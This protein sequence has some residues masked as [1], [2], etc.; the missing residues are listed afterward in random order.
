MYDTPRREDTLSAVQGARPS[1]TRA[2]VAMGEVLQIDVAH[3]PLLREIA[4]NIHSAERLTPEEAFGLYE[5]YWRHLDH[6]AMGPEER[7]L[8][9]HLTATVGNGVLLV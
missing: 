1:G 3:Y 6:Q 9:A 8:V 2:Q 5:R 4:W 7:A